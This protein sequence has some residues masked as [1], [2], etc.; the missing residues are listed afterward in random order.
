MRRTRREVAETPALE[1]ELDDVELVVQL[2]FLCRIEAEGHEAAVGRDVV[3][4]LI[5]IGAHQ[6]VRRGLEQVA[7]A[8]AQVRDKKVRHPAVREP[9]VP[10]AV[11][12]MLDAMRLDLVFLALLVPARLRRFAA[13]VRPHPG[14]ESDALAV[15]KPLYCRGAGGKLRQPPR[16]AAVGID[17]VDLWLFVLL[18]LPLALGDERDSAALRR[19]H[20]L[21]VLFA[22]GRE[23]PRP[24]CTGRQ[25]PQARGALVLP[26]RVGRQRANR[27]RPIWR[28]RNAGRALDAPEIFD[29]ELHKARARRMAHARARARAPSVPWTVRKICTAFWSWP[30]R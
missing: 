3:A 25:E 30:S 20:R 14:N 11:S 19:P 22:A 26:H 27:A 2:L 16:F 5:R 24:S 9:V 28:Q 13:Q 17:Q 23:Q 12:G 18:A 8:A 21:P 7:A 29:R 6:L 10:K 15:G 4:V 1:I